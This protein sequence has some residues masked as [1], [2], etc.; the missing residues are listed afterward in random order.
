MMLYLTHRR[1]WTRESTRVLHEQGIHL[2][3]WLN[4]TLKWWE[5]FL[6]K[7]VRMFLTQRRTR[8]QE[9]CWKPCRMCFEQ[10]KKEFLS[11]LFIF[12]TYQ[13]TPTQENCWKSCARAQAFFKY[14]DAVFFVRRT[15]RRIRTRK[16]RWKLDLKR[17]DHI[18]R[19]ARASI[20]SKNIPFL[21]FWRTMLNSS[22][23][24]EVAP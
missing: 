18:C 3:H 17:L 7:I 24:R 10:M 9:N 5:I 2:T 15:H 21:C 6:V 4:W 22:K 1:N 16:N 11:M 13:R 8:T 19:G 23:M 20:S 14:R 12:L